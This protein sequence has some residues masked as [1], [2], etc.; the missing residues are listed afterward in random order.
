MHLPPQEERS[1]DLKIDFV[2]TCMVLS[3]K[4][5]LQHLLEASVRSLNKATRGVQF[6]TGFS[7]H[8]PLGPVLHENNET[9][10]ITSICRYPTTNPPGRPCRLL[11]R[12]QGFH[13]LPG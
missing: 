8:F 10:P 2:S 13:S 5:D 7:L 1:D 4:P 3:R 6:D 9:Q 11:T 12:D